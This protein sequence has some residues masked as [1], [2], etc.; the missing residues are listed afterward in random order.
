M[1]L[2][3]FKSPQQQSN[4]NAIQIPISLI[5]PD[6]NQ[7][8]KHFDPQKLAELSQSIKNYGV[9]Q[10]ICV[11]KDEN[12]FYIIVAGERRWRAAK[13]AGL[14][15]VPAVIVS[16]SSNDISMISLIENVQREN[17]HF[18]EE[19]N[20]YKTLIEE[21]GMTQEALAERMGKSQSTIANKLRLLKHDSYV[22]DLI[23]EYKLT[24]RHARALLKIEDEDLKVKAL[25][26]IIDG[27]LTVKE[28]E[29]YIEQLLN[30]KETPPTG[31]KKRGGRIKMLNADKGMLLSSLKKAVN[32][33]TRLGIH[34]ETVT[35]EVGSTLHFTVIISL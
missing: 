19:A 10:P 25:N 1:A 17:L 35:T 4:A 2:L 26:A 8:R 18:Y 16:R 27:K 7:P 15:C 14:E 28:T 20:A 21:Y 30:P 5:R 22:R 29:D 9:I 11:R 32:D 3:K 31:I 34:T 33:L 6:E 12:G 24:E 13:E 23:V